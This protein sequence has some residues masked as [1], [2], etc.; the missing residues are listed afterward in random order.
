MQDGYRAPFKLQDVLQRR[1]RPVAAFHA[2][3]DALLEVLGIV[4]RVQT[5]CAFVGAAGN[6]FVARASGQ[7]EAS[8]QWRTISLADAL[9]GADTYFTD[10]YRGDLA[11]VLR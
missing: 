6:A 7:Q 8:K 2:D 10:G 5:F 1:R 11:P 3:G 4:G 9:D